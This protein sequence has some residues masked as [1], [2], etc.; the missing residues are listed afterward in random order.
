MEALRSW[1]RIITLIGVPGVIAIY[2]VYQ[3]STQLPR[4]HDSQTAI[5]LACSAN[6]EKIEELRDRIDV[7]ES[8]IRR[9]CYNAARTN[10]DR[11]LCFQ[12]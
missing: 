5:M 10:E 7:L 2:L 11:N 8:I 9:T 3:G 1:S 6:Q 12:K 4:I